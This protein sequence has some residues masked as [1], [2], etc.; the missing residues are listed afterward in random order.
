[1]DPMTLALNSLFL[2]TGCQDREYSF[3]Q[4]FYFY[5]SWFAGKGGFLGS[6]FFSPDSS[7]ITN[8]TR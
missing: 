6:N 4:G 7:P 2:R 3:A 5:F 8:G 1:M